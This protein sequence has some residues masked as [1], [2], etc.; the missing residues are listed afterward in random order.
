M[1]CPPAER[2]FPFHE[3]IHGENLQILSALISFDYRKR[4][5]A[6][7]T[8]SG[9][10]SQKHSSSHVTFSKHGLSSE[11]VVLPDKALG[12]IKYSHLHKLIFQNRFPKRSVDWD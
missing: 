3:S 11:T 12:V 5:Y 2:V 9:E 7:Q 6:L 10:V 8:E 1:P 4:A